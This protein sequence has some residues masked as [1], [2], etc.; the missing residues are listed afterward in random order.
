MATKLKELID[1]INGDDIPTNEFTIE[2]TDRMVIL[3]RI[4]EVIANLK[5]ILATIKSSDTKATHAVQYSDEAVAKCNESYSKLL[6]AYNMVK[7]ISTEQSEIKNLLLTTKAEHSS[8]IASAGEAIG[9]A[10]ELMTEAEALK[11]EADTLISLVDKFY[12]ISYEPS[13]VSD[14]NNFI[15]TRM[16]L[17]KII[18]VLIKPTSSISASVT[19]AVLNTDGTTSSTTTTTILTANDTYIFTPARINGSNKIFIGSVA[20]IKN[21]TL[22]ITSS[23]MTLTG[24]QFASQFTLGAG[25]KLTLRY[26]TQ[27]IQANFGTSF[28]VNVLYK[29]S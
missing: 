2:D 13:S 21:T 27:T 11:N 12:T 16:A 10:Y 15:T 6:E 20:N 22:T 4:N 29:E 25:N 8:V 23:S 26:F 9:R 1:K 14:L 3:G 7:D 19:N 18:A 28:K 17:G 24:D 5:D